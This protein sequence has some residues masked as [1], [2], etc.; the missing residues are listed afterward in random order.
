[1]EYKEVHGDHVVY[2]TKEETNELFDAFDPHDADLP[3]YLHHARHR[4]IKED[5]YNWL[6]QHVGQP[7]IHW[8]SF[9]MGSDKYGIQFLTKDKAM[10]FKLAHH[11]GVE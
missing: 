5:A 8:Q 6:E 4:F 11:R 1:M 9:P 7:K 3:S 2:M 10:L